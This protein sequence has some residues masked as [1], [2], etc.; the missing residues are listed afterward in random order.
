VEDNTTYVKSTRQWGNRYGERNPDNPYD[1]PDRPFEDEF[2]NPIQPEGWVEEHGIRPAQPSGGFGSNGNAVVPDED[3][4]LADL[5]DE[6]RERRR[7]EK[8]MHRREYGSGLEDLDRQEEETRRTPSSGGRNGSAR[9]DDLIGDLPEDPDVAM[10]RRNAE[11]SGRKK[12]GRFS[13][14]GS[15]KSEEEPRSGWT[16]SSSKKSGRAKKSERYG[17]RQDHADLGGSYGQSSSA[18]KLSKGRNS[19]TD[20]QPRPSNDRYDIIDD[21]NAGSRRRQGEDE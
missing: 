8:R 18:A 7:R 4:L 13:S 3:D 20:Y 6:E 16:G 15:S 11:A 9:G 10:Y 12:G 17:I 21:D 14:F 1:D 19:Q 2:G 5:P